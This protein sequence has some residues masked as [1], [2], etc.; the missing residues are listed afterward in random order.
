V[1]RPLLFGDLTVKMC[2]LSPNKGS[3][4][5][6]CAGFDNRLGLVVWHIV[7][8][9]LAQELLLCLVQIPISDDVT[10]VNQMT[11]VLGFESNH[12]DFLVVHPAVG[13]TTWLEV[14]CAWLDQFVPVRKTFVVGDS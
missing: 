14:S 13:F 1:F 2:R 3:V 10:W 12:K 4:F 5:G 11:K 9:C 6:L 8:E 7:S